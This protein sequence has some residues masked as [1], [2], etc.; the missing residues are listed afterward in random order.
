MTIDPAHVIAFA[1]GLCLFVAFD[2]II[3]AFVAMVKARMDE[4][5]EEEDDDGRDH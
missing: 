4:L 2:D 5:D 3:T 1:L